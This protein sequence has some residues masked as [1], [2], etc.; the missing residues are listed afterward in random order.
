MEQELEATRRDLEITLNKRRKELASASAD[1]ADMIKDQIKML[2]TQV[3]NL[4]QTLKMLRDAKPAMDRTAAQRKPVAESV[5]AI[6]APVAAAQVPSWVPDGLVRAKATTAMMK[7]PAGAAVLEWDGGLSCMIAGVKG[8]SLGIRD[9]LSLGF[10]Q[11]GKLQSQR[12]FDHGKLRWSIE[13]HLSSGRESVGFYAGT[14]K[15]DYTEH[16]VHTRYNVDGSVQSQVDYDHGKRHGWSRM[17]D[18]HGNPVIA[19]R[20]E[21]GALVESVFPDGRR[22]RPK[23]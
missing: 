5:K 22:E 4:D 9:G 8:R 13:Y 11:S 15:F 3:A 7:C 23:K 17:Y 19:E 18:Q 20:Y 12:F 14:E 21:R 16:G 6:M 10:A 1:V 2:E